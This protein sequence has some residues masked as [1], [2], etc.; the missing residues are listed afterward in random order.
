MT[1]SEA[2]LLNALSFVLPI[3]FIL[4]GLPLALELIA[5]N[6]VYEVRTQATLANAEA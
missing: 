4:I 6:S 1:E 2:K 5:P 3:S